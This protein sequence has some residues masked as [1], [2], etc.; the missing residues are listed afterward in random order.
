MAR[1]KPLWLVDSLIRLG[2]STKMCAVHDAY[3]NQLSYTP[4]GVIETALR[5]AY[6]TGRQS[7]KEGN[8]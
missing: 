6:Q 5:L 4:P 2:N 8:K 1:P 7:V 3:G